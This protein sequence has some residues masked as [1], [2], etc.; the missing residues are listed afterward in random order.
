MDRLRAPRNRTITLR[1]EE[2]AAYAAR[3]LKTGGVPFSL[4]QL[5]DQVI[6]GE[7]E[8]AASLLPDSFV[9]LLLVD[10]PYNLTKTYGARSFRQMDADR[11]AGYTRR[12]LEAIRHTLK[13]TAS[14]YLCCDWRTSITVAPVLEEFF[15]LRN[16]ITWQREK[17]RGAR[18][19]WKNAMEDIWFATVSAKTY[20]FHLEAVKQRRRVLAPYRREDGTP[21]DWV[22]G[23]EGGWR[24]TCPSN[25][26]DDI[27][28]PY[29]SMPE[30]TDHPAQKP[31]KLFAKLILAS[32]NPGDLIFD[33]FL[34]SGTAAVTAKKLGRR[35]LGI[36]R[37]EEYCAL[38][39]YRLEQAQTDPRIQG[40]CDGVFWE[41]NTQAMQHAALHPPASGK[42]N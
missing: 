4:A 30:N 7:M 19:N 26:W 27:S 2:T 12:W 6:W 35:F 21:K 5:E 25:F 9:D 38:A 39:Q 16:R 8:E 20:T 40:Y 31:E 3:C 15:T 34:G 24:D 29:W 14:V 18:A 17:G 10:P 32:S 11:Y 33:P 41:R 13:P 37:E 42:K 1:P 36:E 22:E 28:V 23:D